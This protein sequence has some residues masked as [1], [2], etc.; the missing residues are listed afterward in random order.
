M[1][2]SDIKPMPQYFNK[3]I[4]LVEDIELS[5]AF[6]DSLEQLDMLNIKQLMR[7]GDKVFIPGKWTVNKII[8]HLIDSE[9]ILSYRTLLFARNDKSITAGFDQDFLADNSNADERSLIDL[10]EELKIVRLSTA[11][12][13]NSFDE[14]ILQKKGINW[15]YEISVLGMGFNIIG[16]QIHHFNIIGEKYYLLSSKNSALGQIIIDD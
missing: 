15:K 10:I 7:L 13:F 14:E 8:Q 2:K 3:Y 4:D 5:E 12:L 11:A 1:K 16:H 6:E 9:R